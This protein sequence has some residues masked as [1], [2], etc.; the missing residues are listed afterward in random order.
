MPDALRP[1]PESA[2]LPWHFLRASDGHLFV[3]LYQSHEWWT[4]GRESPFT[5]EDIEAKHITYGVPCTPP[6]DL[7]SEAVYGMLADLIIVE[8]QKR[9]V[10]AEPWHVRAA[11][12]VLKRIKE[13]QG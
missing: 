10:S 11:R 7:A 4:C 5:Q 3:A 2:H 8:Q 1:P 13:L 9:T 6:L 12:A